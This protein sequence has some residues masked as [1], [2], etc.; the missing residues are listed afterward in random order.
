MQSLDPCSVPLPP[1]PPP[2]PPGIPLA[3]RLALSV[4]SIVGLVVQH[5]ASN[6]RSRD[7]FARSAY[8]PTLRTVALVSRV[9]LSAARAEMHRFLRFKGGTA[10]LE[11][12][13]YAVEHAG[14]EAQ[15]WVN[16]EVVLLE[17]EPFTFIDEGAEDEEKRERW[18]LPVLKQVFTKI[19]G[20]RTL[21][22]LLSWTEAL[23]TTLLEG[24]NW[25]GTFPFPSSRVALLD[26]KNLQLLCPLSGPPAKLAFHLDSLLPISSPTGELPNRDWSTT[27]SSL[28]ISLTSL[29]DLDLGAY[30]REPYE[31][32]LVPALFPAAKSLKA[33]EL[34]SFALSPSSWRLAV[35]ALSCSHLT[36]LTLWEPKGK[37]I[38]ELLPCFSSSPLKHLSLKGVN[39]PLGSD[40]LMPFPFLPFPDPLVA[41]ASVLQ[42]WLSRDEGGLQRIELSEL[43]VKGTEGLKSVA[44]VSM[45]SLN[46]GWEF[47]ARRDEAFETQLTEDETTQAASLEQQR[48]AFYAERIVDEGKEAVMEMQSALANRAMLIDL[49]MRT[50]G[51]AKMETMVLGEGME[52]LTVF[53][54]GG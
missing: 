52:G 13:L 21:W 54:V 22:V 38:E 14:E 32:H 27:F 17:T 47:S 12:W 26:L 5:L 8:Y 16:E 4:P 29:L 3:A 11:K 2:R 39:I 20:T 7:P 1:S 46:K 48:I 42:E 35:F 24:D 9:F 31:P 34:P 50:K 43:R 28:S 45:V 53:T 25:E 10:Q 15:Y 41:L 37:A 30:R 49:M 18:S 23:P 36:S 33:L 40:G 6:L 19:R 51:K 44:R